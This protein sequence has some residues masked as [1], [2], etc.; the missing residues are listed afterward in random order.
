LPPSRATFVALPRGYITN[1]AVGFLGEAVLFE[2]STQ[3]LFLIWFGGVATLVPHPML[4]IQKVF[5]FLF[6]H[7]K[8]CLLGSTRAA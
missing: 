1:P 8:K 5:L 3:K 4:Q 6:V 2:K 7:K